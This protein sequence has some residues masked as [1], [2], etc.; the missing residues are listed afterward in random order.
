MLKNNKKNF[1]KRLTESAVLLALTLILSYLK[2]LDLPYGGSI[3][4]CS[5]LPPIL[6]AYRFGLVWGFG[7]GFANGI[8][9]LLMGLNTLSY[10]TSPTAAVAIILLDYIIAFSVSG[11]GGIFK[12]IFKKQ[13]Y[14]IVS[15]T[16]LVCLLRYICHVISG[17]TV[18]AGL[19]IPN[20]QAFIYSIAYNATYMLPELIIAVAGALYL[21][22]AINFEGENLTRTKKENLS[23]PT[24][25]L[26]ALGSL[27]ALAAFITDI[28]LIAP[29]L[30]NAE[31]GEFDI[32]G[33]TAVNFT[34]VVI[35]TL[36]GVLWTI[37]FN[38]LSRRV[39][40]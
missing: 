16:A 23:K 38:L 26:R 10:A 11:F 32:T 7:V 29:K 25:Y 34:T 15:G 17:C 13:S 20:T 37:I 40:K 19:S 6:I 39:K 35:V 18:W 24:F 4:L 8:L 31:T 14:S 22:S 33:I 1:T 3:T 28:L 21:S 2:L 30:Q 12:N 9:Q 5:M 36:M 27:G